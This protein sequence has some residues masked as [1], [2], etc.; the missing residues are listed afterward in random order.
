MTTPPA[1]TD[2]PSILRD[3]IAAIDGL[4]IHRTQQNWVAGVCDGIALRLGIDP[5]IVRVA[6]I[7]LTLFGGLGLALYVAAWVLLPAADAPSVLQRLVDSSGTT[8]AFLVLGAIGLG[9]LASA[10]AFFGGNRWGT[11]QLVLILVAGAAVYALA[12][13]NRTPTSPAP[14][15]RSP[16]PATP[17]PDR[18]MP[19]SPSP[20]PTPPN[21]SASHPTEALPMP[22]WPS[23]SP[24]QP[25]PSTTGSGDRAAAAEHA[26]VPAGAPGAGLPAG[27]GLGTAD[28][29]ARP[30]ALAGR[31]DTTSPARADT[32]YR[33]RPRRRRLNSWVALT[34]LGLSL[35]VATLGTLVADDRGLAGPALTIGLAAAL[36][37]VTT[38][39]VIAALSGRRGGLSTLLA[40]VLAAGVGASTVTADPLWSPTVGDRYWS[41]T[42]PET[43]DALRL[44]VGSATLDLTNVRV[45][46]GTTQVRLPVRVGVGDLQV[47]LPAG[48]T[49]QVIA[50][51][52]LGTVYVNGT[53]ASAS[54]PVRFEQTFGTGTAHIVVDARMRLGDVRIQ[55]AQQ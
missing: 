21:S 48:Q 6:V 55:E 32:A 24:A 38:V 15:P 11:G 39:L 30:T 54:S 52:G 47:I 26:P 10:G 45:E 28:P 25:W 34:L 16:S 51:L 9:V 5:V 8:V 40:L 44:G 46:A 4:R 49:V 43:A 19:A 41:V 13:R 12:S 27:L 3:L 22:I 20:T 23:G 36:L 1:R 53:R 2:G 29:S 42:G 7:M 37:L 50:D 31:T 17:N 33:P 14:N 35:I 18:P